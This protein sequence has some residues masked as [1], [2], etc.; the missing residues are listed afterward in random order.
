MPHLPRQ[1]A[2]LLAEGLRA[3][4]DCSRQPLPANLEILLCCLDGAERRRRIETRLKVLGREQSF[5]RPE[6][7]N[8][9]PAANQVR[10]RD[11]TVS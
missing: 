6:R 8:G 1:G 11:Q 3:K 7:A 10:K 4:F 9:V 5:D 2:L